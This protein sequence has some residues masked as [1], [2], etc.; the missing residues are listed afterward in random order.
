MLALRILL[1]WLLPMG[2]L[3]QPFGVDPAVSPS[4][5]QRGV[6]RDFV[7][8]A[9]GRVAVSGLHDRVDGRA[10]AGI[11]ILGPDG[12]AMPGREPRCRAGGSSFPCS[13]FLHPTS[14]GGVVLGGQFDRVDEIPIRGLA[15]FDRDGNLVADFD[16]LG[17]YLQNRNVA[18]GVV[19]GRGNHVYGISRY[20]VTPGVYHSDVFRVDL[21]QGRVDASVTLPSHPIFLHAVDASGRVYVA[22]NGELVRLDFR[23]GRID[24]DWSAGVNAAGEGSI[25]YDAS[26]DSLFALTNLAGAASRPTV[27]RIATDTAVGYDPLWVAELPFQAQTRWFQ[28]LGAGGG[29]VLAYAGNAIDSATPAEHVSLAAADGTI[30]TR[31]AVGLGGEG[32]AVRMGDGWLMTDGRV[33]AET[34]VPN[35]SSLFRVNAE[36]AIDPGFASNLRLSTWAYAAARAADGRI[37]LL[38]RYTRIDGQARFGVARLSP[39]LA[40]DPTWPAPNVSTGG[41]H[42]RT[43]IAINE[44][45]DILVDETVFGVWFG[46]LGPAV[47][48][49]DGDGTTSRRHYWASIHTIRGGSGRTFYLAAPG[50]ICGRALFRSDASR[51][52]ATALDP[53]PLDT[54]WTP[55]LAATP[56]AA[57]LEI[58]DRAYFVAMPSPPVNTIQL[59]RYALTADAA[60]DPGWNV[61]I[62]AATG[63][64]PSVRTM[65]V[66]GDWVYL[67]GRFRYLNGVAVPP[68]ARVSRAGA[69]VDTSW[70]PAVAEGLYAI[71]VDDAHV[72]AIRPIGPSNPNYQRAFDVVRWSTAGEGSAP[73]VL[74]TNGVL[75]FQDGADIT[76]LG[77]GRALVVGRFTRIGDYGRDG[78]A[79]VGSIDAVFADGL[80]SR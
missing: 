25:V 20:S 15:R 26:T 47:T 8:L 59:Q 21:D 49:I 66:V 18:A 38:G 64:S 36:L 17:A 76:A 46:G 50:P 11:T 1:P 30:A 43:A 3:A 54:T 74:A 28:L 9:D 32:R 29:R 73:D 75:G 24:P 7:V 60:L 23:R 70:T 39:S 55:Q 72:Y 22:S 67:T 68:L 40:V 6:A 65:A 27:V 2:V 14:D 31:R 69:V 48:V 78:F 33:H 77:D 37:A 44:A 62:G 41:L 42:T 53:C 52:L 4:L 51:L 57:T 5:T 35:G 34:L 13:G 45:G 63:E 10:R 19:V 80:E 71:A 58:A 56:W 12:R 16:P 79:V 61:T